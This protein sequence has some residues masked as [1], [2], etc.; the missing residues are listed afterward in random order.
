MPLHPRLLMVLVAASALGVGAGC[1]AASP[2]VPGPD[3]NGGLGG[4][5]SG[6]G[7]GGSS[8]TGSSGGSGSSGSTSSTGSSSSSS[9]TSSSGS[10]GSSGGSTSSSSGSTATSGPW[11]DGQT[12]SG[13]VT[14]PAGETVTI[15]PGA[16]V[17]VGSGVT[18]TVAG[19]LTASSAATHAKLTGTGWTGIVVGS[20]GTL[21]L[22]GADILGAT[23]A[24][25]LQMGG[26]GEYDDGTIT[27]ASTPFD[28]ESGG[29]LVTKH[30]TVTGTLGA[31]TVAGS[32]TASYLDYDSNGNGGISTTNPG[33]QL[34]IE[35]S[36]L[37]GSGPTADF[38]VAQG[39]A[40]KFHV[41]YSDISN[42]HCAFH[43]DN[44]SEFDVSYTNIHGNAWGFMLYG[45]G[46]A[47]P[48][49][50]THSNVDT[51]SA[52]AY[53]TLGNNGPITFDSDYVTG[54]TSDPTS[55]VSVTNA[56]SGQ[57]AGTGPR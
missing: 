36:T 34:S 4:G 49:T 22:D 37:H 31:S 15:D 42:V 19:T 54:A 51:N 38:L 5:S 28:V 40:T 3:G 25:D 6:S 20:G 52:Y 27:A 13:S 48:L 17:N 50:V 11:H 24:L 44:V 39:G 35:D 43:F 18:I 1:S 46:G 8:S 10:G 23:T 47:G 53:G 7:T 16:T 2:G 29:S 55:T 33:A 26:T 21:K 9:S 57:V 41:A 30:A 56:S 14:I 32:L 45:S 12:L